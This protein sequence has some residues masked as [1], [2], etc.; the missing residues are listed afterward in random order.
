MQF[1]LIEKVC[2]I[3]SWKGGDSIVNLIDYKFKCLYDL[4]V[5]K[6]YAVKFEKLEKGK[7]ISLLSD[8]MLKAMF[9]NEN[10]IKYSAKFLSYFIDVDYEVIL[11]NIELGKNE[12]DEEKEFDKA[13]RCDYIARLDDTI[14]NI[15]VNN[16]S[17]LEVLER[18]MKYAHRLFSKKVK[19]EDNNYKYS[20]VIQINLNN[21][22]FIS[23]NKIIDI[24]TESNEDNL[25][26]SDKLVF[27]Q[28]YVPNLR[29]K[30]YNEGEKSLSE[31]EKYILALVEMDLDKLK[32]LGDEKVMNEYLKEA[33][34]VS[35]EEGF[36]EAYDK[37]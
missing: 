16:N 21:F 7:K 15:E 3:A 29:K 33:E 25:V 11:N 4:K 8:T 31:R 23:N 10:R 26:L 35:F 37:E 19:T 22:S 12:I 14:L 9:Q 24:Y 28:I 36:G 34:E 5:D 6:K 17:S 20:Q 18:N 30:W 2:Y 1:V 27:I 32:G 13:L